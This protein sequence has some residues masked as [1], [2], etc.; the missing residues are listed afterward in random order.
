MS[1]LIALCDGHGMETSGKR[2]PILPNGLQSET[3]NFMHENEFNRAVVKYLK[4]ELERNGFR[5]LLVA[6]TD[7][8]TPLADRTNL[9]NSKGADLY[10]SIHANANTSQWGTWGGAETFVHPSGESKRIGSVIHKHLM[11]GTKLRDRGVK[12]G[13]HLWVIRKTSMPAVLV[14]AAFMDNLEEAK[15]LMSDAFRRECAIE[16]AK[17]VCESYGVAYQSGGSQP[18]PEAPK[19]VAPTPQPEPQR[20]SGQYDSSWFTRERGTFTLNTTI[21][22]RTAPFGSASLIATLSKGQ[23]ISYDG[24]GMEHDGHVWIRQPRANGAYGYLATGKSANGKRV[25]YWGTFK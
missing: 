19:P 1:K 18:K 3:G 13:S 4:T 7:Y 9:A 25:D 15:L 22:L 6:P 10:L 5:V 21:N 23:S 20:P 17:G 24:Y 8:D 11:G 16:I 12:D 14:E 2:T